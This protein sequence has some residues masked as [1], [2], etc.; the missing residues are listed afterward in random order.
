MKLFFMARLQY[1]WNRAF[2]EPALDDFSDKLEINPHDTSVIAF[3]LL[4]ALNYILM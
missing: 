4:V 2:A 3:V 1:K